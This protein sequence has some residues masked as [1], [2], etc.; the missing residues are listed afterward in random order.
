MNK[1]LLIFTLLT[2]GITLGA[3][4]FIGVWKTD[5]N[6]RVFISTNSKFYYEY[7]N[8]LN[9]N[10]SGSGTTEYNSLNITFP[11]SGNYKIKLYPQSNEFRFSASDYEDIYFIEIKNWG[12]ISWNKDLTKLFNYK[13]NLTISATDIPDFANVTNFSYMFANCKKIENIPN[14]NSW[15]ISNATQLDKMFSNALLFNSVIGNWNTSKVESMSNMFAGAQTFNQ[16]INDW[17]TSNVISMF[18][19]FASAYQFN[20]TI[21]SWNTSKV[22]RMDYMFQD[23]RSFNQSISNWQTNKVE[24]MTKM[25]YGA[26]DFD[27][28][29]G[30][31]NLNSITSMTQMLDFSGMKCQ[32]YNLTL[33]G[34]AANPNTPSAYDNTPF[35][36]K[37]GAKYL[38]YG[39]AGQNPRGILTLKGYTFTED[40]FDPNCAGLGV[41]ENV[42]TKIL[43]IYPNPISDNFNI[44]T[45]ENLKSIEVYDINGRKIQ[46]LSVNLGSNSYSLKNLKN[47]V[48]ILRIKADDDKTYI[49][50]VIKK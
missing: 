26:S 29:I 38:R 23:A 9:P 48:Y 44:K 16:N 3:S 42:N 11:T 12:E 8:I 33:I 7:E 37:V 17:D 4:P 34:W 30:H 49:K 46:D 39:S 13:I 40:I 20:Q 24:L 18:S 47:S 31:F 45:N 2:F 14:I 36:I 22:E 41:T 10:I 28:N 19:M 50:K 15:N 21:N 43:E 1:F 25:F 5:Q 27:Q 32:N 35:G 6:N